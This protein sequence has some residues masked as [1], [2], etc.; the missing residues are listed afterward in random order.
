MGIAEGHTGYVTVGYTVKR[1]TNC[2]YTVSITEEQINST[3]MG[4]TE[5]QIVFSVV[6]VAKGHNGYFIKC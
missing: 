2:H 4:M 1:G 6:G 3:K 5:G